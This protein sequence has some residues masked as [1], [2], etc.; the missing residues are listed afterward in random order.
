MCVLQQ[1]SEMTPLHTNNT[2]KQ[3][4]IAEQNYCYYY[5]EIIIAIKL[6]NKLLLRY[7]Y[8]RIIAPF[9]TPR[10]DSTMLIINLCFNLKL[11]VNPQ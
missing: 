9:I 3:I 11:S 6:P 5:C 10:F 1:R 2:T 4:I 8:Y 7:F